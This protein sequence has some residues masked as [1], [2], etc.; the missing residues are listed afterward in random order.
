MA[1]CSTTGQGSEGRRVSESKE[2]ACPFSSQLPSLWVVVKRQPDAE[3]YEKS[4]PALIE[5][6][7][8]VRRRLIEADLGE[9]IETPYWP[10]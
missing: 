7:L 10:A 5:R 6:L 8:E 9:G 1:C 2:M 3:A 4:E